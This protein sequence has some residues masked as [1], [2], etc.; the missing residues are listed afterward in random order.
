[1]SQSPKTNK[2]KK[3]R[4]PRKPANKIRGPALI[5]RKGE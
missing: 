5:Q 1:M 4:K 2:K 3:E